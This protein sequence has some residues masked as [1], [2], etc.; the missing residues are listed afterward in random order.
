MP[1]V[2]PCRW[3]QGILAHGARAGP[4]VG[5]VSYWLTRPERSDWGFTAVSGHMVRSHSRMDASQPVL[6][7]RMP[8]IPLR[9]DSVGPEPEIPVGFM[10]WRAAGTHVVRKCRGR[11]ACTCPSRAAHSRGRWIELPHLLHGDPAS[12]ETHRRP[13]RWQRTAGQYCLP[14]WLRDRWCRHFGLAHRP[15]GPAFGLCSRLR[16]VRQ[17]VRRRDGR[18]IAQLPTMPR[19]AELRRHLA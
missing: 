16:L 19:A 17:S 15:R 3:D 6:S 8:E 5:G 4:T 7:S 12:Q 10:A 18:V 2:V 9:R 13:L 1:A 14:Q 11:L